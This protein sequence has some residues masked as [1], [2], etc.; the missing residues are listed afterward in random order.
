[1]SQIIQEINKNKFIQDCE[2]GFSFWSDWLNE[3]KD[4]L[5]GMF[6]TLKSKTLTI[7]AQD[8]NQLDKEINIELKSSED[9]LNGTKVEASFF[10]GE[11]FQTPFEIPLEEL[12]NSLV[13]ISLVLNAKDEGSAI[14]LNDKIETILLPEMMNHDYF[15]T[16][17]DPI[18]A[19]IVKK[20]GAQ[21]HLIFSKE[22]P[23]NLM[24][25][26]NIA[27]ELL[28]SSQH[29]FNMSNVLKV[30]TA[31]K[32]NNLMHMNLEKLFL[33]LTTLCI[34][35][36]SKVSNFD[37]LIDILIDKFSELID[38]CYDDDMIALSSILHIIKMIKNLSMDVNF[39]PFGKV[40]YEF[41]D[42]NNN[43]EIDQEFE[44]GKDELFS[45]IKK[46]KDY[47]FSIGL[48]EYMELI[49]FDQIEINLMK[50]LIKFG[51]NLKVH[52]PGLSQLLS[53]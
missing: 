28:T 30:E 17:F 32:L 1:M 13:C 26:S 34:T 40:I 4:H 36:K 52:I 18:K 25:L 20:I 11:S 14:M 43:Q 19:L 51:F 3:I 21:I 7:A 44:K 15:S 41:I 35:Y 31:F 38:N 2:E 9:I 16:L 27:I 12:K 46:F 5:F 42:G 29:G 53:D 22:V 50:P 48:K 24:E 6:Q 49:N 8:L 10:S 47:L 45:D 37:F 33:Q 23:Q 39:H